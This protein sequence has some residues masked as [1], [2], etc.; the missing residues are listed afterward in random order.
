[1]PAEEFSHTVFPSAEED[2][3]A[4]ALAPET[5]QTRSPA[6]CSSTRRLPSRHGRPSERFPRRNNE[7]CDSLSSNALETRGVTRRPNLYAW[8]RVCLR[9][10]T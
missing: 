9:S 10:V 7:P 5:P 1:M 4:A 2:V 6:Y 3:G 8:H